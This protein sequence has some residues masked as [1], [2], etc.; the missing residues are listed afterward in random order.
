[1]GV[2]FYWSSQPSI[3]SPNTLVSK[4]AHVAEYSILASLLAFAFAGSAQ[5]AARAWVVTVLY[6]GT[7]ELHQ[8]FTPGRTPSVLDVMLDGAAAAVCL[9]V[10]RFVAAR[11]AVSQRAV[12]RPP[13]DAETVG[14]APLSSAQ[15]ERVRQQAPADG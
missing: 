12:S 7:D 2:I 8:G 10:L 13:T 6:A 15:S 3:P 9:Q 1:M 11:W 4:L 14:G 5:W